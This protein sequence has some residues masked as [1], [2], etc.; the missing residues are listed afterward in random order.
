MLA[1]LGRT[2]STKPEIISRSLGPPFPSRGTAFNSTFTSPEGL[3]HSLLISPPHLIKRNSVVQMA[4][5][6][7]NICLSL[8]KRESGLLQPMVR[9]P[10]FRPEQTLFHGLLPLPK[11]SLNRRSHGQ[12]IQRSLPILSKSR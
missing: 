9:K 4:Q 3:E 5:R 2:P 7:E 6:T 8:R 1:S 11:V 10:S 12:S